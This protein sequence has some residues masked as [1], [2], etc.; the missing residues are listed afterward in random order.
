MRDTH[1][2]ATANSQQVKASQA[3]RQ[4]P[5]AN[6]EVMR[7]DSREAS[8][9][10]QSFDFGRLP[11]FAPRFIQPKSAIHRAGDIYEQ[12]A[13]RI[14]EE[15]LSDKKISS[16][17]KVSDTGPQKKEAASPAKGAAGSPGQRANAPGQRVSS[18]GQ[19]VNSPVQPPGSLRQAADSPEQAL[20]SPGQPLDQTT[21]SFFEPR[22]GHDFGQVRVHTG[23]SAAASAKAINANAYTSG[24]NVVFDTGQYAPSS[25]AGKRLL[26]HELTHVLQQQ[27]APTSGRTGA[28]IQRQPKTADPGT[29]TKEAKLRR[30]AQTLIDTYS[31]MV[32]DADMQGYTGIQVTVIHSGEE[33]SPGPGRKIEPK[34]PRPSGMIPRQPE[35]VAMELKPSFDMLLLSGSGDMEINYR[36]NER[37]YMEKAGV[38]VKAHPVAPAPAPQQQAP[39]APAAPVVPDPALVAK[40]QTDS[41][42]IVTKLDVIYYSDADEK[43]VMNILYRWAFTTNPAGWQGEGSYFLQSLFDILAGKKTSDAKISYYDKLFSRSDDSKRELIELRNQMAPG[44]ANAADVQDKGVSFELADAPEAKDVTTK[45]AGLSNDEKRVLGWLE[46][47]KTAIID[48]EGAFKIDRRAIAAA[49]AWEALENVRGSWTPSS[50]GPGKVHIRT[51]RVVGEDTVAKQVEDAGMVPKQDM[52]GRKKTLAT[53]AGA[54]KYVAAIM[55]AGADIAFEE[56]K[57]EI[58]KNP[59]VLCFMYQTDDLPKWRDRMKKKKAGEELSPGDQMGLWAKVHMRFLEEAVG[60]PAF[61]PEHPAPAATTPAAQPA[62]GGAPAVQKSEAASPAAGR[63]GA[64]S[65]DRQETSSSV[66]HALSSPSVA[67]DGRVKERMGSIFQFSFD[68]V[69]VH[70]NSV[71]A[72][73]AE[74]LNARA[75]TADGHMVFGAGQYQPENKEGRKLIAHELTHVVQQAQRP[76]L[77]KDFVSQP[78]EPAEAEAGRMADDA[79]SEEPLTTAKPLAAASAQKTHV[80]ASSQVMRQAN[81]GSGGLGTSQ[82]TSPVANLDPRK[83]MIG[84]LSGEL[85]LMDNAQVIIDWVQTKTPSSGATIDPAARV[86][87]IF[88]FGVDELFNDKKVIKKLKPVP[89]T[90]GD[91]QA[92]LDLMMY[93]GVLARPIL[94]SPA[95][96]DP[97]YML[98][99]NQQTKQPD[100]DKFNESHKGIKD[101]KESLDKREK[102]P[103]PLDPTVETKVLPLEMAAGAKIETDTEKDAEKALTKLMQDLDTLNKSGA[104]DEATQ[105]KRVDLQAKIVRAKERYRQA[106]GFHTFASDVEN[107]LERLHKINTSWRAGTYPNHSWG[108]FSVDIFLS[109]GMVNVPDAGEFSGN[110]WNRTVVRTFFDDLNTVAEEVDPVTGKFEWRAIYNDIPLAKEINKKFGAGRVI[111]EPDHGPE[112]HKL[113]IHLDLRPI[114]QRLDSKSGYTINPDGRI[115]LLKK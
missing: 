60:T 89:K 32:S 47:N 20:D 38:T 113:H 22:F 52:E 87:G 45:V 14:S 73:S 56:K 24:K 19:Q 83:E 54:I 66:L 18:P 81:A 41:E 40:V 6:S 35:T 110:F 9:E 90:V 15:V 79:V 78:S 102:R 37:G 80:A 27:G 42:L 104:D 71:A 91:L 75:Y 1:Q 21:R 4:P 11:L 88:S 34:G 58:S 107:L 28:V 64:A 67:L 105:K 68:S 101:F 84:Q 98:K 48:A 16:V 26:A 43:T 92:I 77:P 63:S 94:L 82:T 109:A 69:K 100:L 65:A 99:K 96:T 115:E 8:P 61:T 57:F 93:Y 17:S 13:D 36:R 114:K 103:S 59:P 55:K 31:K 76:T 49:I 29:E 25:L 7:N 95:A 72:S 12:E 53:P 10:A 111:Q 33:L 106:Q 108:E 97:E 50:V 62:D 112:G 85:T 39:A 74:R 86:P 46:N 44:R 30:Q 51:H 23:S 5:E 3:V 70:N 2:R